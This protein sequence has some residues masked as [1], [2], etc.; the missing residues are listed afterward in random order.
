MNYEN[1]DNSNDFSSSVSSD[2]QSSIGSVIHV[3]PSSENG[4]TK[5]GSPTGR[6]NTNEKALKEKRKSGDFTGTV[7][8]TEDSSSDSEDDNVTLRRRMGEESDSSTS[9]EEP[10][11]YEYK[12]TLVQVRTSTVSTST[13]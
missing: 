9:T 12:C 7:I 13:T 5:S 3:P 6:Q 11:R 10:D 8:G 4:E 2:D 1:N